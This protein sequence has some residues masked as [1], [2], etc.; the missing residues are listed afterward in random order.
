MSFWVNSSREFGS[1]S[2]SVF[3]SKLGP[4]SLKNLVTWLDSGLWL[5]GHSLPGVKCGVPH[6]SIL[7]PVVFN[8][9]IN[10]AQ[11]ATRLAFVK[12]LDDPIFR[13]QLVSELGCCPEEPGQ[14]GKTCQ[15]E[16]FEIP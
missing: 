4:C 7:G 10:D 5:I 11:E 12:F 8:N 3:V 9:F 13:R 6:G 2:H 16:L 15:Q 14:A 1:S